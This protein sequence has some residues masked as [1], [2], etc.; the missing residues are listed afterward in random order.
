[1]A[2]LEKPL[3]LQQIN[4]WL[5][6]CGCEEADDAYQQFFNFLGLVTKAL[7][8]EELPEEVVAGLDLAYLKQFL[9]DSP[10]KSFD[11]RLCAAALLAWNYECRSARSTQSFSN[12]LTYLPEFQSVL[13]G[14]RPL[15]SNEFT[16]HSYLEWFNIPQFRSVQEDVVQAILGEQHP[17]VLMPTGGGKSL[18]YQLPALMLFDRQKG[19]TVVI[20]PLQALMEDQVADLENEGLNFAT[21]INGNLSAQERF[22]RLTQ[23]RD[24]RKGLLYISPEQLR[25]IG[26]RALLQERPPALWVIDEVHCI[27]QWG[28][29]FR[30]DYRYIPKYIHELYR[31]R[32][33]AAP[34]LALM[35]AT[36]TVAVREDIKALFASNGLGVSREIVSSSTRDNLTYNLIPT[37]G[38]KEQL[39]LKEIRQLL[40]RGGSILIY[41]TTRKNAERVA[42]LLNQDNIKA[43]YYHGKLSKSEKQEVLQEFKTG[44]LNVVV[45]TC[46]FGMGIN[47][48]DVRAVVHHTMSANLEGYVQEAGRAGRDGEPAVCILLFDETDADTIFFLQSLNQLSETELRNIFLSTRSLRDRIQ[49]GKTVTEDWFWVTAEEI[50]QTSDLDETFGAEE[51]QRDTKIKVA[52][53]NLENF[54]LLERAENQTTIVQFELVHRSIQKSQQQ[55]EQ[56]AQTRSLPTYQGNEFKQL[57]HATHW[58]KAYSNQQDEPLPLERLGD[59]S[60]IEA[61][62]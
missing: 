50:Y 23:L 47:R 8:V 60:G 46:A 33:S 10:A 34:F 59:A 38:H 42:N 15:V 36:A 11:I 30:P 56:Y 4:S 18:C 49:G 17:L 32:Q 21:F 54:S 26:I 51:E 37:S 22:Q 62:R 16:Y 2:L 40:P 25:S 48:K 20:S 39:L 24:G 1:M 3:V 6:T 61:S 9:Q 5:L 43:K 27:S 55:F 44:E 19:L 29:D 28:H 7:P 41:T 35:T 13:N 53:H 45:A 58:V 52:L 57:I 14:L 31:D 12:W